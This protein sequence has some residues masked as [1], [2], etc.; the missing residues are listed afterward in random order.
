MKKTVATIVSRILDPFI[1]LAVL[2]IIALTKSSL[3]HALQ[4][5]WFIITGLA[6]IGVPLGLFVWALHK[7]KIRNWDIS[8]RGERPKLFLVMLVYETLL[9]FII[10]PFMDIFLFQTFL[11]FI[12]AFAGFAFITLFWKISGHAFVSAL[13]AGF[14]IQWFGWIWWPVLLIVLLVSWSRVVRGDHTVLQVLAGTIYAWGILL[15]V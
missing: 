14:I 13:A 8:D 7:G 5:Q 9:L 2:L 1:V 4:I 10:R 3:T 15:I 12:I 6:M 11:T